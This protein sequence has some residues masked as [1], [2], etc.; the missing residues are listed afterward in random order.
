LASDFGCAYHWNDDQD[1]MTRSTTS[2]ACRLFARQRK[3]G[4]LLVVLVLLPAVLQAQTQSTKLDPD[5]GAFGGLHLG[6]PAIAS[7]AFGAQREVSMLDTSAKFVRS[8]FVLAEPGVSAGRLSV[9]YGDV[10][11]NYL[12]G[13]TVRATALRIWRGGVR[14]YLGVEGSSMVFGFQTRFGIFARRGTNDI[15]PVRVTA[16]VGF[17]L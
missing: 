8:V 3:S 12:V 4:A 13:L 14:N 5:W 11:R 9:G 16:D 2:S 17:G 10:I 15:S 1:T 6:T 7:I